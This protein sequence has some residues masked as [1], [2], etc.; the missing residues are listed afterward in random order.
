MP[1][2]VRCCFR[3]IT[4]DAMRNI[5]S[6]LVL[7]AISSQAAAQNAIVRVTPGAGEH[8]SG[9]CLGCTFGADIFTR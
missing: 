9:G 1:I 5:R 8:R 2:R 6:L 7:L 3:L 4:E